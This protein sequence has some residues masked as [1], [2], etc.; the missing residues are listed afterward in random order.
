MSQNRKKAYKTAV[1]ALIL[2]ALLLPLS[3]NAAVHSPQGRTVVYKTSLSKVEGL[4]MRVLDWRNPS[5]KFTF[6][7]SDTDW[8]DGLDLLLSADPLGKVSRRSTLMVQFNGGEPTPVI[9]RGRGFDARIKLDAARMRPRNNILRFTYNTPAGETCLTPE[10][11]GWRLDF[12]N[13]LVIVK[14]RAKIRDLDIR[15][16]ET[17]LKN[18]MM[19][20]KS[21]RLL[22]RG[23]QTSTLQALAA[24]GIGLRM[25]SVPEF[26]TTSGR[27]EFNVILG[28]RDQLHGLISDA[29]IL[30]GTG[31][32]I[33]VHKGYPMRLVITGDTDAEVLAGAK[34]FATHKLPDSYGPLTSPGELKMQAPFSTASKP[35][36]GTAKLDDL[37]MGLFEDNWGPKTKTVKFNVTDPMASTGEVLLRIASNKAVSDTSR[38]SVELNGKSLGFTTLNKS[39]KSV[40]FKIP[41]GTLQGT[42]NLLSITPELKIA[43]PSECNHVK[44]SPG[45]Y[46]GSGSKL[47]IETEAPSPIAELSK[48]TATGGVFSLEKASN[49]VVMLPAAASQ[50]YNASLKVL[51]KLAKSS[52][53][54]WTDANYLRSTNFKAIETAKNILI[55]GPSSALNRSLQEGAPKGLKSALKGQALNGTNNIASIDR[56]AANSEATTLQLYAKRQAASGRIRSGGVAA[57]YPSPL[58]EN[59]VMG[60]ITNVPGRSFSSVASQLI[61]PQAWNNLEGSVARWDN[62]KVVMA[63]TA[64]AVPGFIGSAPKVSK[65]EGFKLSNINW[66]KFNLPKFEKEAFEFGEIDMSTVRKKFESLKQSGAALLNGSKQTAKA[67]K[68]ITPRL[69]PTVTTVP[70]LRGMSKLPATPKAV[71]L[72]TWAG[73]KLSHVKGAWNKVKTSNSA[74]AKTAPL[75]DRMGDIIKDKLGLD[76]AMNSNALATMIAAALAFLFLLLG[77]VKPSRK[78]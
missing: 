24:Q 26:K 11:G 48:L 35:I 53:H 17:K 52:G 8:T 4:D 41:A 13:S 14:A 39:R 59:N 67:D 21:V 29:R 43:Q 33:L 62:S 44:Q 57:L 75:G 25:D 20:P 19:A 18:P 71:K 61:K 37:N 9:T 31:A 58:S 51:A 64:M 12:K 76:P 74:K 10:Q 73:D 5:L 45:F 36:D 50:D 40:G 63:Q 28:R 15:D 77:L 47:K 22:A 1:S 2:G 27:S 69:K 6:D 70:K 72:K 78:R 66:S 54:G 32:R 38:V 46:L 65:L 23:A 3:A 56:F 42:D 7:A 16:I 34:A 55:I 30:N 49:T 68:I 60:V